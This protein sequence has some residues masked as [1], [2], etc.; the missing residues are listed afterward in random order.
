MQLDE[1]LPIGPVLLDIFDLSSAKA[2]SR[3]L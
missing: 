3:L 2:Q 1:K